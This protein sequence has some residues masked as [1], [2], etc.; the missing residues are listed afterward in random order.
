MKKIII[1]ILSIFIIF[2]LLYHFTGYIPIVGRIISYHS[3]SRYFETDKISDISYNIIDGKY[4]VSSGYNEIKIDLLDGLISDENMHEK[5]IEDAYR[6]VKNTIENKF[7]VCMPDN[8]WVYT[9]TDMWDKNSFY[10][11]IYVLGIYSENNISKEESRNM[12]AKLA[13]EIIKS[14]KTDGIISGVQLSYFDKNDFYELSVPLKKS[15]KLT[16]DFL[17]KYTK[18][19]LPK[20]YPEDY[21]EWKKHV[22]K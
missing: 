17:N 9:G 19:C 5:Q 1:L 21:T 14:I 18:R 13:N 11:R 12:P 6:D 7:Q 20:H 16:I 15:N 10:H 4:S 2:F 22:I 8:I 3:A